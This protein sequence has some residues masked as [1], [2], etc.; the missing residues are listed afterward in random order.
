MSKLCS[1]TPLQ[2]IEKMSKKHVKRNAYMICVIHRS[3]NAALTDYKTRMCEG[4]EVNLEKS[5]VVL[6]HG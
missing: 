5:I 4:H 3:L 2:Q 1:M 6:P